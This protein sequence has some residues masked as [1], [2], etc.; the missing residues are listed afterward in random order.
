[1]NR[2]RD[3]REDRDLTQAELGE[4]IG[5]SMMAISYYE[6]EVR[7]LTP[8]LINKFCDFY[9]VTAD[10]L[11]GRSNRSQP[12][13]SESDTAVLAAY[14]AAPLEIRKI[15]DAALEPYKEEQDAGTATA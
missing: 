14:H 9:G 2:L 11:L 3:L 8:D 13:V 12:V 6:R 1:M 4:A 15:V 5:V 7:A 10:Y